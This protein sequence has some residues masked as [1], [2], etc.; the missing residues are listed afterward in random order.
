MHP[1]S[2][3][4]P[5]PYSSSYGRADDYEREEKD[6]LAEQERQQKFAEREKKRR[7]NYGYLDTSEAEQRK[8]EAAALE[9]EKKRKEEQRV[10]PAGLLDQY[11][12]TV[13]PAAMLDVYDTERERLITRAEAVVGR[14]S[15]I[16]WAKK[17]DPL[18]AHVFALALE[19][20]RSKN[21]GL[22]ATV[23][24]VVSKHSTYQTKAPLVG[25]VFVL[26]LSVGSAGQP[27]GGTAQP[28]YVQFPVKTKAIAP[29]ETAVRAKK[30]KQSKQ[31]PLTKD[32]VL[33]LWKAVS[34]A[35]DTLAPTVIH[36]LT[37]MALYKSHRNESNPWLPEKY[38]GHLGTLAGT[39]KSGSDK[40]K[41]PKLINMIN[42][43]WA[44]SNLRDECDELSKFA[45]AE[46]A[47]TD[48]FDVG[49]RFNLYTKTKAAELP[50]HLMEIV[51]LRGEGYVQTNLPK[52]HAVL[53]RLQQQLDDYFRTASVN[54]DWFAAHGL[55]R[56]G[57]KD[58]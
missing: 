37:H 17:A 33:V 44:K 8:E 12:E 51:Y 56:A 4:Y 57:F 20:V 41:L 14:I 5:S 32:E 42:P 29:V 11:D 9:K 26:E 43:E 25:E 36:E 2:S 46:G 23:L 35:A 39:L 40:A 7:E 50:S 19:R 6:A 28:T 45:A 48:I 27:A 58:T 16:D 47:P 52:G 31:D 1:S 21:Q 34:D 10:I 53:V 18:L 38:G 15:A 22:I 55:P 24:N 30:Q 54:T 3:L 13:T 49:Q